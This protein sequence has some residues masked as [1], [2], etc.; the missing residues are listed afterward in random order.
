[1]P[2]DIRS[3]S[4]RVIFRT[5]VI[6]W[7]IVFVIFAVTLPV[8]GPE[9]VPMCPSILG[10]LTGSGG[11]PANGAGF[12]FGVVAIGTMWFLSGLLAWAYTRWPRFFLSISVMVGATMGPMAR[13]A[14]PIV[15]GAG[16]LVGVLM[17]A[18]CELAR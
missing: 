9:V 17:Q 15:M 11:I 1:M 18:G 8:T 12:A 5:Q 6:T 10:S 4:P 3:P 14:G 7:S 2:E 16:I 13:K